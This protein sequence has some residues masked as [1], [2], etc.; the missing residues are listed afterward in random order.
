MTTRLL[1]LS[2]G[3][4]LPPGRFLALI[5]VRGWVDLRAIVQL[6]GLDQVK[7]PITSLR[8]NTGCAGKPSRCI[9]KSHFWGAV[10]YSVKKFLTIWRNTPWNED[11]WVSGGNAPSNPNFG[12]EW[13]ASRGPFVYVQRNS[14]CLIYRSLRLDPDTHLKGRRREKSFILQ[15][16]ESVTLLT[17]A[18]QPIWR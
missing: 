18:L 1:A 9:E 16:I 2:S 13:F 6:E 8:N 14:R 7:N 17:D 10:S 15:I 5:S 4:F 12:N 11:L 3:H